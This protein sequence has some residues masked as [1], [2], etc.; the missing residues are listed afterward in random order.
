VT[1]EKQMK[2][3]K[4]LFICFFTFFISLGVSAQLT[5]TPGSVFV[6]TPLQFVQT[7][8]VGSGVVVSNAT[9]NGSA[10]ALN[11]SFRPASTIDQIGSF[12]TTGTATTE[13]GIEG[14]VL[15][16]SGHVQNA[17]AGTNPSTATGGLSDPDLVIL[18]GA[19]I[20][21]RAVLEFDFVP[22]TDLVSFNYVF[23][24]LEFDQYCNQF[25]DAFGLFLS[26]PG[27]AGGLGFVNN[28]VNIAILPDGSNYVNINNICAED[29][30]NHDRGV[31]SWWNELKQNFSLNRYTY[32]FTAS[33][34]VQCGLLYHMKFAIGDAGDDI[35]D[36][37]VFLKQNSFSSTN[38]TPSLNFSNPSTGQILVPGCST[39]DLVYTV[40]QAQPS[41]ITIN[42]SIDPTGTATQANILPNPFPTQIVLTAGQLQ[43]T[44]IH[45]EAVQTA[46][47][48]P[49]KTLIIKASVTSC[50]VISEVSSSFTIK[51]NDVLSV[52]APPLTI[53]SGGSATLTASA[54]GGQVF[55][56]SNT[57][58]Y[59]WSDGST[60]PSI[61]LTPGAGHHTYSVTI[62]DA[63]GQT[64]TANTWID[65]GTTPGPAGVISGQSTICT[66]AT[67]LVFSVPVIPGADEYIWTIPT[68][69][70][71]VGSSNSNSITLNFTAAAVP[72]NITVKGHSQYCGDGAVSTLPMNIHPNPQPAGPISGSVSLCQGPSPVIYSI[73]PLL[74]VSNYDWSVPSGVTISSGA[75]TNQITCLITNTAVSGSFTVRGFNAECNFGTPSTLPVTINPL[76]GPSSAIVS[77]N[78]ADICQRQ[79]NV[80]YSINPIPNATDY[81]WSYTGTGASPFVNGP[82]QLLN[83]SSTATSGVLTVSGRNSCGSGSMSPSFSIIVKPKPTVEYMVCNALKTTKN[84]KPILLKGGR[85]LGNG[86]VYSGTGVSMTSPGNY[87]F[88]PASSAVSGGG[89]SSGND[90]SITYNYTNIQG[91]SDE[92]SI[93]ISVF[94]SNANAPCPGTVKDYRDDQIYSTLMIGGKCWMAANLNFGTYTSQSQLQTDD[95]IYEKYC[96]NNVEA[97]CAQSGGF[98]Q[99]SE[100]M[101]HQETTTIQ[102]MCPPGWHVPT[103]QEWQ[104]MIDAV[105]AVPFGDG[106]AGGTLKDPNMSFDALLNGVC[107]LNNVWAFTSG[108]LT[109]TLFWT[110]TETDASHAVARGLNNYN[111][112]VSSTPSSKANAYQVRCMRD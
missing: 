105:A 103:Q 111:Y 110:S 73:T 66:P 101:E 58:H 92:Q 53:C 94:A 45:I 13:L 81:I 48:G 109:S 5:V 51:Y 8:L 9:F 104:N 27:I 99:W 19:Q 47:P 91:C 26:G 70:T 24:S 46:I 14:G 50:S 82:D 41:N 80:P 90:Y 85:P 100:L 31:Y 1:N 42:L 69:A 61:T 44:P 2:I 75:G 18:A 108:S 29:N 38:I 67:A 65:V 83:F 87:I 4:G 98:Y 62:T 96:R 79:N 77:A 23:A 52:T 34:T 64:A 72:G 68:G 63:C 102:N 39:S 3:I 11:S 49:D 30:G 33:Y 22:E 17:V 40:P 15:F 20:K 56:P 57:Y 76:P 78:G 35:W 59:L 89:V 43:T 107:Y 86:G 71:I 10:A 32:V 112:S 36:S 54:T 55:I 12:S 21:D 88:D 6:M 95:C 97:Q 7:Y 106:L 60:T 16:S 74:Y 93:T 28:A 37:E 25:N 84:G